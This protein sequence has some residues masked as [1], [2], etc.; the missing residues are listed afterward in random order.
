[1]PETVAQ[2]PL[3]GSPDRKM[4]DRRIF[5]DQP[6]TNQLCLVCGLV[7]QSPRMDAGELE[8][9]YQQ[10]Y[11]LLYQ[12]SQG[13]SEKDLAVQRG[14]AQAL[15][16]LTQGYLPLVT[17]HLDLGC[18]AGLLLEAFAGQYGCQ[19]V[20]VEPGDAYREYAAA[21]GL[22]IY[23]S[24][25]AQQA[26]GEER[27]DLISLAHVLEHIAE[28]V[29]YL[30][31][32]RQNWLTDDGSL[33]VE[34]PNLYCHDSFELAHLV[35]YSPHSLMQTL[36]QAGFEIAT[37]W[38]HGRPRSAILP[39][40][41]TV[42]ARPSLHSA[43]PGISAE[44]WV[45]ARRRLGLLHRRLLTRIAPSRAWLLAAKQAPANP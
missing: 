5:R 28:P 12:G 37:L 34:V 11:R 24:L 17:R 36:R 29:Q 6:V 3:C 19:A 30:A 27:F 31:D 41:L 38:Q 14:R 22:A 25:E 7:Y 43:A 23:P 42:L 4:F 21:R 26:A 10:E 2:C 39:L 33:L 20:G 45:P 8:A 1:M 44:R 32:L 9:F 40:Y 18:S 35:A 16:D 13:P 15:L